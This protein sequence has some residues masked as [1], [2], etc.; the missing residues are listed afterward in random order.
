MSLAE[1][2]TM[3]TDYLVA[4]CAAAWGVRLARRARAAGQ[5]A[6]GWWAVAF[7]AVALMALVG[8]TYHGFGP[9]LGASIARGLWRVTVLAA[10][11]VGF[12]V[13]AASFYSWLG[14]PVRTWL[15]VAAGAKLA[16]YLGW[17]AAHDDYL[18]VILDYGSSMLVALAVHVAIWVRQ[19][20]STA[21]W[22]C[23]GIL[24]SIAAAVVQASGLSLH[25]QFDHNVLYH[26][27]QLAGLYL[28][29]R[30]AL[31]ARDRVTS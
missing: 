26:L 31:L 15:M 16:L 12:A 25:R 7:A 9:Q 27:I 6:V 4:V 29:Y 18:W 24:V 17:M 13:L 1:P 28:F 2:M 8:G 21:V 22:I 19:R 5:R 20:Q 10:G 14:G 30:G 3:A 23:A 11:P